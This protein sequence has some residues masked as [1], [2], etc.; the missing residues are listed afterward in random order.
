MKEFLSR[1]GYEFA[2]RDVEEDGEAYRALLD[3]GYRTVPVTFIA[4]RP[5]KGFD[6]A[7]LREAIAAAS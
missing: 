3:L 7:A 1:N 5:I 4:G 2:A 6:E